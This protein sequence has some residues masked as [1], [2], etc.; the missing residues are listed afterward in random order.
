MTQLRVA[1]EPLVLAPLA[2]RPAAMTDADLDFDRRWAQW[3]AQGRVRDVHMRRRMRWVAWLVG[4]GIVLWSALALLP[5][6]VRA[7][8]RL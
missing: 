4:A 6:V 5:A 3:L 1:L 7:A 8:D 2:P